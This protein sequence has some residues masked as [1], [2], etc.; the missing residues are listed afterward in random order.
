MIVRNEKETDHRHVEELIRKAFYNLYVPGCTEH[1]L[2]R[3]MRGHE[4]F[5]PELDLVLELDGRVIGSILYTKAKLSDAAGKEKEILTFG[6]VCIAPEYQRMGYGRRLMET[7]FEKAA[8]LGYD[9]IVIFAILEIMVIPPLLVCT[10][11]FFSIRSMALYSPKTSVCVQN[12]NPA[13]VPESRIH[14]KDRSHLLRRLYCEFAA[15]CQ[16]HTLFRCPKA[17][18]PALILHS[19][20]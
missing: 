20:P 17:L 11:F 4:D 8:A 5:I 7:S 18:Q 10:H 2:A 9:V 3:V 12:T 19:F 16:F 1:Y 13:S 6:P 14:S 15:P